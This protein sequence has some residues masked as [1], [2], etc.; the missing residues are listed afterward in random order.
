[1]AYSRTYVLCVHLELGND[2]RRGITALVL[3]IRLNF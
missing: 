2:G 3:S 1:V